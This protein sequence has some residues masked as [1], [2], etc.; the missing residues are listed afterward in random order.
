[1]N[2]ENNYLHKSTV[3]FSEI[4]NLI[5]ANK[6]TLSM[7]TLFSGLIFYSATFLMPDMYRS[8]AL[9]KTNSEITSDRINSNYGAFAS[10]A[11]ISLNQNTDL[12]KSILAIEVIKSR[13]FY[14]HLISYLDLSS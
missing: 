14:N 6:I 12:D 11:G 9:L 4:I 2:I 1:M 5:R 8:E 13:D 3:S 7:T 10:L